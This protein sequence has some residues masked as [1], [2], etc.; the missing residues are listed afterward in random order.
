M[1]IGRPLGAGQFPVTDDL[2][3]VEVEVGVEVEETT[4]WVRPYAARIAPDANCCRYHAYVR[5]RPSRSVISGRKP[6]P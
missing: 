1:S 3:G 6:R 2:G 5:S 4:S